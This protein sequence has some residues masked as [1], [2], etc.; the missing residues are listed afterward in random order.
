[1][2]KQQ[3]MI[4]IGVLVISFLIIGIIFNNKNENEDNSEKVQSQLQYDE[5]T[6]IILHKR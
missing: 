4:G 1:M 5:E 6:R 3:L 2:T